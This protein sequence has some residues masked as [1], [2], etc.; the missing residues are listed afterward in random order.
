MCAKRTRT[1]GFFSNRIVCRLIWVSATPLTAMV[2]TSLRQLPS[3]LVVFDDESG[4][5][6]ERFRDLAH[7][8]RRET[9]HRRQDVQSGRAVLKNCEVLRFRRSHAH[10]V[11]LLQRTG[12]MQVI[13]RDGA[14]A[15]G[16]GTTPGGLQKPKGEAVS[17]SPVW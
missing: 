8:A 9:Q 5:Q 4:S 14:F 12:P 17:P 3:P 15:L 16:P 7:G 13:E 10:A 6:E 11:D 1:G 2:E